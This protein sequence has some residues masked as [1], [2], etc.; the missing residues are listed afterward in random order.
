MSDCSPT[1][2]QPPKLPNLE[3]LIGGGNPAQQAWSTGATGS[4]FQRIARLHSDSRVAVMRLPRWQPSAHDYVQ[5]LE[6]Q[7]LT[8][9]AYFYRATLFP[10]LDFCGATEGQI[11]G[12]GGDCPPLQPVI[13]GLRGLDN[14]CQTWTTVG[15]NMKAI[16]S[17]SGESQSTLDMYGNQRTFICPDGQPRVFSW[18]KKL[19]ALRLDFFDFSAQKRLLAGYVG[20][21]LDTAKHKY[22]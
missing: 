17:S 8:R 2:H 14:Y 16:S 9:S 1:W 10:S 3:A 15:F 19:S 7:V 18:R 22:A 5:C 21:H 20:R 11:R 4:L 13:R 6:E 12:L